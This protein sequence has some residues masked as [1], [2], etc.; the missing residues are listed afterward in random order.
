MTDLKSTINETEHDS[1]EPEL[2]GSLAYSLSDLW[3]QLDELDSI[4]LHLV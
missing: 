3:I 1:G 4:S 2:E